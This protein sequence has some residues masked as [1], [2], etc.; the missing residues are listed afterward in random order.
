MPISWDK[1]RAECVLAVHC[2]DAL[3]GQSVD[4]GRAQNL[5]A[6][7]K[8]GPLSETCSRVTSAHSCL[9]SWGQKIHHHHPMLSSIAAKN[10]FH[11]SMQLHSWP[12]WLIAVMSKDRAPVLQQQF[13]SFRRGRRSIRCTLKGNRTWN[14]RHSGN[15][16]TTLQIKIAAYSV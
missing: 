9:F 12:S 8:T 15:T 2:P 16:G 14:Q 5:L 4:K 3:Q 7:T 10:I 1:E 6:H 11:K 13:L